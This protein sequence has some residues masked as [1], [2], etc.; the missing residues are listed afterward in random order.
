M[1]GDTIILVVRCCFCDQV[2]ANSKEEECQKQGYFPA[3]A[4]G[5]MIKPSFCCEECAKPSMELRLPSSSVA[6]R[7]VFISRR[8][9]QAHVA[10][11]VSHASRL[12]TFEQALPYLGGILDLPVVYVSILT[13]SF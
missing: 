10:A 9:F 7:H 6:K 5:H 2:K 12:V 3:V 11:E 4:N 8:C 1:N 13:E